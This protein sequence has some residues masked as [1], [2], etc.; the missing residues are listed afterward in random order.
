MALIYLAR[1]SIRTSRTSRTIGDTCSI[2]QLARN[3]PHCI[4]QVRRLHYQ[5]SLTGRQAIGNGASWRTTTLPASI[6]K[7][8]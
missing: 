5:A 3:Q 4:I 8:R 2:R 1:L 7:E 6:R